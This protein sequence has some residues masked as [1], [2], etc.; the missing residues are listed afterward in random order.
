LGLITGYAENGPEFTAAEP[1]AQVQ[2]ADFPVFRVQFCQ[3]GTYQGAKFFL[4]RNCGLDGKGGKLRG[5]VH[6]LGCLV[7]RRR[8]GGGP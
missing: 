2:L 3:R 4:V 7:Q 1:V 8:G 6:R 5:V